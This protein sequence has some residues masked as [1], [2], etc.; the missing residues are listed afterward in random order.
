MKKSLA[1][2][3]KPSNL[4]TSFISTNL[5]NGQTIKTTINFFS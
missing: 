4:M 1:G 3:I 5:I 2:Q